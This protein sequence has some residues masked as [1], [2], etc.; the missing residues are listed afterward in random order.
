MGLGPG[1]EG[2][3]G[4]GESAGMDTRNWDDAPNLTSHWSEVRY[5]YF[6]LRGETGNIKETV[7][8]TVIQ[9]H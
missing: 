7:E 3:V 2:C 1:G 8:T 6:I 5:F 4:V 9:V